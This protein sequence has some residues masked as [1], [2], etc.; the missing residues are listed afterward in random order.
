MTCKWVTREELLCE[1]VRLEAKVRRLQRELRKTR[2][3]GDHEPPPPHTE[4]PKI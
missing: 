2:L 1:I 3:Q 4:V